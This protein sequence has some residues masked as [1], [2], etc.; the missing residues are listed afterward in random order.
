M[1]V[2]IH[3]CFNESSTMYLSVIFLSF[4]NEKKCISSSR[5]SNPSIIKMFTGPKINT[6]QNKTKQIE[7]HNFIILVSSPHSRPNLK[8]RF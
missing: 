6:K 1:R 3:V 8:L 2:H 4:V 5:Y 7:Q